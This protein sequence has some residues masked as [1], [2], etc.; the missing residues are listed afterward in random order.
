[1]TTARFVVQTAPER[2]ELREAPLPRIG[3][4]DA[5]LEVEACGV[6]GTD[7]EVFGGESGAGLPL[8]P[9]HEPLGRVMAIGRAAK[10]R[11]GVSEGDRV[12]VHSTLT[13]GRCRAC[14]SGLR[15]CSAP[16]F[17]DSTIY[18]FAVPTWPR[19]CGVAS[20]PTSTSRPRR[21][22]FRCPPR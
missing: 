10:A 7:V 9:G 21:L 13:C 15:G 5:L 19:A 12:A 14:R 8:V 16:E 20:P 22:S 6:C 18:G 3:E 2:Y 17:A 1:M 4:D 11:W